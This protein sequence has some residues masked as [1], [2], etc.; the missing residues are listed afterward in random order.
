LPLLLIV[1]ISGPVAHAA[2][3]AAV[4]LG[5]AG[6][7]VILSTSGIADVPA[8]QVTG[9]VGT[10]PITGAADLLSCAEVTGQVLSVDAA[11]PA[12]CNVTHPLILGE[13]VRDMQTA[14]TDAAGRTPNV[15]ELGAGNIG[16]L[17]IHPG[18]YK[19]TS[20]VG[21]ASNVILKGG[22]NDVWIFQIA[23]DLDISSGKAVALRGG[24][25]P[26]NIFWQV[27]GQVTMGTTARFE[28]VILAKTQISMQ[29]GASIHG[30]LFAQTAVTLQ[31]N[32]VHRPL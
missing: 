8:S 21:I 23:Q 26:K 14:Y 24:A 18:V 6:Y 12:P 7:F 9:N 15:T 17:V 13:A 5:S 22:P 10:S 31:M 3:P 1:L 25:R 32:V 16:G 27:A 30:R 20:D 11:G 2:G 29:T 28:G 19:W 4:D